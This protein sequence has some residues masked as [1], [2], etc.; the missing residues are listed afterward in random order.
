MT[1]KHTPEAYA[2]AIATEIERL[3]TINAEL[4]AALETIYEELMSIDSGVH[5]KIETATSSALAA[6]ARAKGES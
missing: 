4:V 1:T 3:R 2:S 6:L 5:P